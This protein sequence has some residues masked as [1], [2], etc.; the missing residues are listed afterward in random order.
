MKEH[1]HLNLDSWVQEPCFMFSLTSD[2]EE[3]KTFSE[4]WSHQNQKTRNQW[5]EAIKKE[6]NN[7]EY[8]KVRTEKQK[9]EIPTDRRL[10]GCKMGV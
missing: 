7:M 9:S 2:P 1:T 3:P 6:L 8:K 4:A 10:A 5:R